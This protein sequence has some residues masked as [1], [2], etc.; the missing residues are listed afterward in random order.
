MTKVD[1]V[2]KRVLEQ[3]TALVVLL[4]QFLPKLSEISLGTKELNK[5]T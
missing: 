1:Y 5:P 2:G 3:I 4:V